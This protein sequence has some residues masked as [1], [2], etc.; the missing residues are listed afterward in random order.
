MTGQGKFL[1]L[2]HFIVKKHQ[3]RLKGTEK[4]GKG[5]G[6]LLDPMRRMGS[7]T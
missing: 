7:R 4:S 2:G 1:F 3:P 6:K 5:C